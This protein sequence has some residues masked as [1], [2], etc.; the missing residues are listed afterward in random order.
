MVSPC[1]PQ[2]LHPLPPLEDEP[3]LLRWGTDYFQQHLQP[4]GGD[5]QQ[6]ACDSSEGI[7]SLL[8]YVAGEQSHII[9]I[10]EERS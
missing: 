5:R 7:M 10:L 1:S 4:H 8:S 6:N 3:L 2:Q 9:L